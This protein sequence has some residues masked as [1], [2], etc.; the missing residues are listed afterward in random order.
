MFRWT[1]ERDLTAARR[2][3]LPSE[4]CDLSEL[5]LSQARQGPATQIPNNV[6]SYAVGLGA[7]AGE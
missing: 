5:L 4:L 7:N 1:H 2:Q 6:R 3:V